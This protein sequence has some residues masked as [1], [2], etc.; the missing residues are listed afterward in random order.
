MSAPIA[1]SRILAAIN[2][3]KSISKYDAA[4]L[5][6]C[7][8]RTAQRVLAKMHKE[9]LIRI[10][11]WHPIYHQMTAVFCLKQGGRDISKPKPITAVEATRRYRAK[12]DK[13]EKIIRQKRA[14]RIIQGAY[15]SKA[16]NQIFNLIV[17][18][19]A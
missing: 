10:C 11:G 18:V 2:E 16:A 15:Q 4:E 17:K 9:R 6:P 13:R 19:A 7:H 5:V 14:K 8:H 3:G 12:P 1:Y